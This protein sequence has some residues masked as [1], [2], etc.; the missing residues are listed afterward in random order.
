MATSRSFWLS[1]KKRK[2]FWLSLKKRKFFDLAWKTRATILHSSRRA[3]WQIRSLESAKH[4]T[5]GSWWSILPIGKYGHQDPQ[6]HTL[7]DPDDR[8]GGKQFIFFTS[9][10]I[11]LASKRKRGRLKYRIWGFCFG[12]LLWP[13][14][15]FQVAQTRKIGT[16]GLGFYL[17]FLNGKY[18]HQNPPKCG[19]AD[20]DDRIYHFARG[21]K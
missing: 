8:I 18:G 7:A 16:Y 15:N 6:N 3:K 14:G 2:F 21:C 11:F 1:L 5:R 10:T 19:L 17:G 4:Q 20:S 9:P 13:I 12:F